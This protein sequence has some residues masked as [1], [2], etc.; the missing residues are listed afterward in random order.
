M[1]K[2]NYLSAALLSI[3]FFLMSHLA[4]APA[5]PKLYDFYH[6]ANP[7]LTLTSVETLVTIPA[8]TITIVV[9]LSNV[10]VT[11]LGK[12]RTVELGLV[13]ILLSGLLSFASQQFQLVLLSRLLLGVGIGLYNSLSISLI[14]DYFDGEKRA[15]MIGLRTAVLNIGK[16]VT[17]FLVGFAMLLGVRYI[18]LVYLLAL[19]VL[20]VFHKLVDEIPN[21]EETV[22]KSLVFDKGVVLWML[23]TFLIGIAYIGATVKIP[24]L[25]VTRYGYSGLASSQMLTLLAFS[26]IVLGIFFGKLAKILQENTLP[27][28]LGM[29]GLGNLMFALG[30]HQVLFYIGAI[31]IGAS[32]VGGMSSVF[33]AIAKQ[34][35]LK[36][37]NFV[38]SMAITAGNIGVILTPLILTK[39]LAALS[40]DVFVLPFYLT[41]GM[42][43]LA[44]VVYR[45]AKK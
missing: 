20:L 19:P 41:A 3:S 7:K 10:I 37:I 24:S 36:Q 12:K 9:I 21:S 27:T 23:I 29:I 22:E 2:Q 5:I 38:T 44:L 15:G 25:M 34:Y 42:M 17:T 26:G 13:L 33:N 40:L 32:F 11:K 39:L 43:V 45:F 16:T 6:A 14:S 8:M 18:F 35:Q 30:N 4:I 31:L 1:K 28:M